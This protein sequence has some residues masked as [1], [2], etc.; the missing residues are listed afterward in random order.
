MR[1]LLII[2][3]L[4]GLYWYFRNGCSNDHSFWG[5]MG[6]IA[7][8]QRVTGSGP[9]QTD[10]RRPGDFTAIQNSISATVE[11]QYGP[12]CQVEVIAQENLIPLILTTIN[13]GALAIGSDKNLSS[14]EQ[15]IIRVTSPQLKGLHIAGSGGFKAN[16]PIQTPVFDVHIAGSGS[17]NASQLSIESLKLHVAGSGS[18]EL[19]GLADKADVHIAGSGEVHGENLMVKRLNAHV[20]GSGDVI[21]AVSEFLDASVSGSG[22]VQYSGNP[23]V[24]EHVSGTGSVVKR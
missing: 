16:S 23:E 2:F 13:D 24:R 5:T 17:V 6:K 9:V 22:S 18:S 1:K 8:L 21:C 11:W 14:S 20:A 3:L 4:V 12:T 7:T 19:G 15:M 10:M